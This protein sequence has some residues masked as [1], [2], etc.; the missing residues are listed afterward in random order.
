MDS[1]TILTIGYGE[2][3]YEEVERLLIDSQVT[4]LLDVRSQPFT[5]YKPEFSRN[6]LEQ[7]LQTAGI[8]YVFLG[9]ELGDRPEDESCYTNGRVDYLK[10]QEKAW[11]RKGMERLRRAAAQKQQMMLLC[12]E[13]KPQD[14]HR[15]KLIGRALIEAG[16]AILHIDEHGDP[17]TQDEIT[18]L[19]AAEQ[20]S[21][22]EDAPVATTSRKTYVPRQRDKTA[23]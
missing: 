2:R 14:C 1:V 9:H 8:R 19:M 10:V 21:L 18:L 7:R 5:R 17:K 6:V 4:V 13:G 22:F 11:F 12:S 20:G 23:A 15:S 16:L 3:S